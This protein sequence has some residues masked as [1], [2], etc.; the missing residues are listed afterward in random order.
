[1][2]LFVCI[3]SNLHNNTWTANFSA[4]CVFAVIQI[5][6]L[7]LI[8]TAGS[9]RQERKYEAIMSDNY[10]G[11]TWN[12]AKLWPSEELRPEFVRLFYLTD[13]QSSSNTWMV[14]YSSSN[15]TPRF[16][17]CGLMWR[18]F[19]NPFVL[20]F[21]TVFSVQYLSNWKWIWGREKI[22][23]MTMRAGIPKQEIGFRFQ[24][25]LARSH[26]MWRIFSF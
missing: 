8:T 13:V 4:M 20:S 10:W 2:P 5:C 23:Q 1:M 26:Q 14:L 15:A 11:N 9:E 12:V 16:H 25:G 3:M 18:T 17:L 21:W 24:T 7:N 6:C 19:L 22:R